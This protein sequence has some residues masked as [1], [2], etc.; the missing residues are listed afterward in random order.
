MKQPRNLTDPKSWKWKASA[1]RRCLLFCKTEA[2]QERFI[3]REFAGIYEVG[4]IHGR[5]R[6][7]FTDLG[8]PVRK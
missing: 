4:L 8:L 6:T 2:S 7:G 1:F 3:A 5:T